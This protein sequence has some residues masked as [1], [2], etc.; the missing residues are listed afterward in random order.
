MDAA[1]KIKEEKN[2]RINTNLTAV[3]RDTR[4]MKGNYN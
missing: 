4:H 2:I 1:G 3:R